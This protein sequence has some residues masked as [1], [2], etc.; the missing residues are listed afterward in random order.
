MNEG[1]ACDVAVVGAGLAGLTAGLSAA[2]R[3]ARVC[4]IEQ[5]TEDHYACNSRYAGGWFHLAFHD[6]AADADWLVGRLLAMAPADVDHALIEA[7]ART[8][9]RTLRWLSEY[10]GAR[11]IKGGP[12]AWHNNLLAP[13]RPPRSRLVWPGCGPDLL[14]RQLGAALAGAGGKLA[15]GH[16]VVQIG[17]EGD[18]FLVACRTA[19]GEKFVRARSLVVCDGGFAANM[20]QLNERVSRQPLRLLQR[21]AG[22]ARG[23]GL[24]LL[25]PLGAG[26][27][28]TKSFYGHL[29][30]P[31]AIEDP[32]LW[33]YP[34]IDYLA[35]AGIVVNSAGLRFIDDGGNGVFV[36]NELA[37][38]ENPQ[39][40]FA[41]FDASMWEEEGRQVRV[42][43]NPLLKELGGSL[44]S[45][46]T[47][48][49]LAAAS[50]IN[51][52]NLIST[53]GTY[54]AAVRNGTTQAL[55]ILKSPTKKALR[56]IVQPPYFAIPVCPGI[57]HTM[58]GIAVSPA[59]AVQDTQGRSIPGLFAA[60]STV[61]GAEG[62]RR[63][64]YLGGLCKAATLGLVCGE[65]A[66]SFSGASSSQ[67][68][69]NSQD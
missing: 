50:D 4:V 24:R 54:N 39:N 12:L 61:G 58:G 1:D 45:A 49:E 47:L 31:L 46:S 66:A 32:S 8:A 43:C 37:G 33:P 27:T 53:V 69:L 67:Y 34:T 15:R 59:G 22:T 13:P 55:S 6:A 41:I 68:R 36:A 25:P 48:S 44:F 63:S 14:I 35:L 16:E 10:G 64:F 56:E 18:T 17:R 26:L 42:P 29:H 60:G 5:G 21:N 11:F 30:S 2:Q 40:A 9:R 57:T 23:T 62:G 51:V 3:G 7:I 28:E 65:G 20:M 19:T 38:A 52:S